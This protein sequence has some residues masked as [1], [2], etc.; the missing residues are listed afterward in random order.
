MNNRKKKECAH[1]HRVSAQL[2]RCGKLVSWAEYHFPLHPRCAASSWWAV[3]W[4]YHGAET[5][6]GLAASLE[7]TSMID[8]FFKKTRKVT[9]RLWIFDITRCR[10]LGKPL[11]RAKWANE[12]LQMRFIKVAYHRMPGLV[13]RLSWRLTSIL[14]SGN[15]RRCYKYP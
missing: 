4:W 9:A 3:L 10:M 15:I 8:S 11:S 14:T 7:C 1:R 5:A 6:I 2:R 12:A 13:F